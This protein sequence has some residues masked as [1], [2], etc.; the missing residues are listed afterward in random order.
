MPSKAFETLVA[1]QRAR[2]P[3]RDASVENLRDRF[4]SMVPLLGPP[5]D[6]VTIEPGTIANLR[7]ERFIPSGAHSDSIVMFL[8]GGGYCIG[9]LNT[10]R[11]FAA[12]LAECAGVSLVSIEYRLAPEHTF[13]AAVDDAITAYRGLLRDGYAAHRIVVGGDSAGGGLALAAIAALRDA[14]DPLPAAAFALSP[15]TDLAHTGASIDSR[16]AADPMIQPWELRGFADR[17]L[18]GSDPRNSRASP[19]YGDFHGYPPLL[20]HVGGAEILRDDSTR[21]V[22]RAKDAG[23]EVT[24]R[25]DPDMIHVWHFFSTL[26]PEGAQALREVGEW[27]QRKLA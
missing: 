12:N 21:L 6:G 10:H 9:S 15:W 24:F 26:I 16:A 20:I 22:Q 3:Q 11:C 1:M 18:N 13:P 19:L 23:V 7:A 27:V 25:L 2:R 8:H 14:R 5:P 4:E 17:Y